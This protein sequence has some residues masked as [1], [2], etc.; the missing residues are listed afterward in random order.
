MT[1]TMPVAPRSARFPHYQVE[2]SANLQAVLRNPFLD[3]LKPQLPPELRTRTKWVY[4]AGPKT[5]TIP[6]MGFLRW[7][8]QIDLEPCQHG[9]LYLVGLAI[10]LTQRW[11]WEEAFVAPKKGIIAASLD[12][13]AAI[14]DE[15]RRPSFAFIE[16]TQ[17]GPRLD[18]VPINHAWEPGWEFLSQ[19]LTG[20]P[21]PLVS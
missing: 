2:P 21:M 10:E 7:L 11:K 8:E 5:E 3:T 1:L 15:L 18:L 4:H 13:K 19:E 9:L 16:M 14:L 20:G 17:L 6:A 12:T